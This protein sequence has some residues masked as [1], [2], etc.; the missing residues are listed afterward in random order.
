MRI[1]TVVPYN[2]EWPHDF[3]MEKLLI[4]NSV[5]ANIF[6]IHHIGST[7]VKGLAAKPIIDILLEIDNVEK[8]DCCE[9][10]FEKIGYECKGEFGIPGRRH[11][12]KG[13]NER[14]HQIHAFEQHSFD[15]KRHIAFRDY[16]TAHKEI[17]EE[18]E[19][20][21]FRSAK[22]CNNDIEVYYTS[23]NDFVVYHE[24]LALEWR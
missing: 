5:S 16:L 4:L 12:Q 21:K 10:E 19:Q 22:E 17:A 20:L 7:S 13:G 11:F 8:L 14:S 3:E 1:I 15:S 6:A 23:K 9:S 24:K 2:E 18:Y